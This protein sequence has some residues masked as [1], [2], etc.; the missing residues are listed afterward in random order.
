M[1]DQRSHAEG[2]NE[3]REVIRKLGAPV[4]RVGKVGIETKGV[5]EAGLSGVQVF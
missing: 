5:F 4:V 2:V 1:G 3:E